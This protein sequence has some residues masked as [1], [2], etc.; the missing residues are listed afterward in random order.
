MDL[1]IIPKKATC[2]FQC[3]HLYWSRLKSCCNIHIMTIFSLAVPR[4]VNILELNINSW[5]S[6]E[7][8]LYTWC[9]TV[10]LSSGNCFILGCKTV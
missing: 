2:Y 6:S 7:F 4:L 9:K 5:P 10:T 3:D 1:P 8:P